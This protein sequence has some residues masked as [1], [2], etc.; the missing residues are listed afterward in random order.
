M[1]EAVFVCLFLKLKNPHVSS[2]RLLDAV[3]NIFLRS[4]WNVNTE[5]ISV[6]RADQGK[7]WGGGGLN[8]QHIT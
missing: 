3:E 8:L 2:I 1:T 6:L 5:L 7:Q 4:G